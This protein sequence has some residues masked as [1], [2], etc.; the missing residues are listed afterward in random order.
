MT[1]WNRAPEETGPTGSTPGAVTRTERDDTGRDAWEAV[2]GPVE[3]PALELRSVK[4]AYGRIQVLHGIDLVVP[5]GSVVAL[6]GPNGAG[7]STTLKVACGQ[8]EP[9]A[10]GLV[11]G[12]RL[13]NGVSPAALSRV[14]VCTIP[15]G[16]G[17]F[18]NL[19]VRD[20]LRM[21]TYAGASLADIEERTYDQFPRL[22]ERRRQ[23]AGTMSG[24]EQQMLAMARALTTNPAVLLLDELS[25][26]LAPRIVEELYEQVGRIAADGV[27]ILIVEQFARTVMQVADALG[28]MLSG[29]MVK[30]GRPD[31]LEDDLSRAYLGAE[32]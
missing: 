30:I 15:E 20:N 29:R 21:A 11:V 26:G 13:L 18:P 6:L 3:R 16:R 17:V 31:E 22:G 4:A 2:F 14:G 10:G 7:K 23:L 5:T 25:M 1:K 19:T 24:G 28:L 12:G 9:T 32:V 8:L 27:S